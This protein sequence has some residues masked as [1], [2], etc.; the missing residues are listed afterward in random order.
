MIVGILLA[1]AVGA[2]PWTGIGAIYG[3]VA[4]RKI[5]VY[6]FNAAVYGICALAAAPLVHW[7]SLLTVG[8]AGRI[9]ELVLV[10]SLS[11]ILDA[12][13]M[14]LIIKQMEAGSTAI[15]WTLA[16]MAMVWP[17]LFGVIFGGDRPM[18]LAW[19]GIIAMLACVAMLGRSQ[20]AH[21]DATCQSGIRFLKPFAGFVVIGL[22]QTLST[23]PSYWKGWEDT[24]NLRTFLSV[25]CPAVVLIGLCACRRIRLTRQTLGYG[26]LGALATLAGFI[27]LYAALDLLG[28]Q[29][30]ASVSYPLAVGACVVGVVG[31]SLT[32]GERL[33]RLKIIGM[34]LGLIGL[35]CVA[36]GSA[37]P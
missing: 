6:N 11:G 12:L 19:G 10:I 33:D 20:R 5:N 8:D 22:A 35:A 31:Y 21:D 34:A 4:A 36:F 29:G 27:G 2:I 16:Q 14:I 32:Q 26:A 30:L 1:L 13:G 28:R 18:W 9:P 15:P 17:F 23:I 25:A 3:L 24:A 7:Q 37:F